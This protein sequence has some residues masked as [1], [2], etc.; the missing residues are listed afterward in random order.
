MKSIVISIVILSMSL[1]LI[2]CEN[3]SQLTQRSSDIDKKELSK[4]PAEVEGELITFVG[5]LAGIDEVLG[6]CPNGRSIPSLY[7]D[8]I[9][10]IQ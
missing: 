4:K 9:R 10:C 6:C 3:K 1:L 7:N 5:D 8:L 2:S